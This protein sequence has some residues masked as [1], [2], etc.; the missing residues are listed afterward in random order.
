MDVRDQFLLLLSIIQDMFEYEC[1][2]GSVP[3][4]HAAVRDRGIR[5]Q[6][7]RIEIIYFGITIPSEI[8][9]YGYVRKDQFFFVSLDYGID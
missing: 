8:G 3:F 4:Q 6:D 2:I 7:L 9:E 1:Q 5:L